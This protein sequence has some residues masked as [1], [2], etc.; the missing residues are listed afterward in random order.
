[1]L[2]VN[3]KIDLTGVANF[4]K[5][6]AQGSTGPLKSVFKQWA[7]RYRTFVQRRFHVFSRGGGDWPPLKNERRHK[8]D[9]RAARR[10]ER[11]GKKPKRA[12]IL[13]DTATLFRAL[14][15]EFRGQPGATED[16][17]I[18]SVVVGYGGPAKHP[19]AKVTIAKL[20]AWHDQGAGHLPKR[21]IIVPP[22]HAVVLS[23]A[24][25]MERK[26]RQLAHVK[27]T[28]HK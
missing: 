10:K 16:M 19:K 4:R 1:M 12:S 2:T 24:N 17:R 5:E 22:S 28:K 23:M 27:I 6:V 15:P 20:A 7:H 8:R 9:S 14:D 25:D 18:W 26:L 13:I 11:K 21:Q 3:V